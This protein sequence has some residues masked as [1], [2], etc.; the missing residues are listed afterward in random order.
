MKQVAI[1]TKNS[2]QRHLLSAM[3]ATIAGTAIVATMGNHP[4]AAGAPG[5]QRSTATLA[6]HAEMLGPVKEM[7]APVKPGPSGSDAAL[8][9]SLTK[10][11]QAASAV[12]SDPSLFDAKKWTPSLHK[13]MRDAH[14]TTPDQ[15]AAF[16]AQ[17]S[18][19]SAGLSLIDEE[20]WGLD[21]SQWNDQ[22]AVRDYF[23]E[24]Y[25]NMNGNGD[26]GSDDGYNYRGRGILQIT[27]K[28][29]YAAVSQKLYGDD[30]L[31]K[32]PE[33]V[34]QP[35]VACAAAAAYWNE[36]DLNRFIPAGQPVTA[37]EFQDLG[38]A[39][40]TGSPG[41]VPHNADER[42]KYW[43]VTKEALGVTS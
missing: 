23:D 22:A 35:D 17:I 1:G 28:S 29:N 30:R 26:V 3:V 31:V 43:E 25:A 5:A 8:L 12:Q 40:N 14:I 37:D 6:S 11:M 9:K 16:L 27:G 41:N 39:I 13:A 32:H 20:P 18:E 38:S 2:P 19:E 24:K 33:Q 36:N 10:A 42:V 7:L 34:S 4:G 21:R 15:E